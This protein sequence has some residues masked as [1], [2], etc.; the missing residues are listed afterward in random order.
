MAN[1]LK[2]INILKIYKEA[3]PE[4]RFRIMMHNFVDF[5]REVNKAEQ[6]IV[7]KIKSEQ[8][9]ARQSVKEGIGVRVQTSNKSD[10]TADEAIANALIDE[11]F[12][13]GVI[14]KSVLKGIAGA[15][16]IEE[17]IRMVRIMRMDYELLEGLMNNL[18]ENDSRIMIKHFVEKKY[19]K[20]IAYEEKRNYDAV[21]KRI[22]TLSQD[23]KEEI[24]EYLAMNYRREE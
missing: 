24:I 22:R 20:D 17:E 2:T 16:E 18:S 9:W 23:L 15:S 3:N 4:E 5:P 10:P 7:F 12:E 14:D 13:T 11:A 8:E 21:K 19:F 6:K 1:E